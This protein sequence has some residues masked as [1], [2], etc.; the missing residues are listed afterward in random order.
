ME[1][2][3]KKRSKKWKLR[4]KRNFKNLKFEFVI[5]DWNYSFY[6]YKCQCIENAIVPLR[7]LNADDLIKR[8]KE[9]RKK[10][11]EK[12]CK[13]RPN[14]YPNP[15]KIKIF[16]QVFHIHWNTELSW[17]GKLILNGF[18]KKHLYYAID[19]ILYTPNLAL[20]ERDHLLALLYSPAISL[21]N[22]RSIHFFDIWIHELYIKK[23]FKENKF[24]KN[25]CPSS[26]QITIKILYKIRPPRK[27]RET[28]W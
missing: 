13:V 6:K 21:H 25:K 18:Q 8:R 17:V 2:R 3:A 4:K 9:E 1:L 24:L 19:D 26:Y 12:D 5:R 10:K 20:K 11:K 14:L 16:M 15:S 23:I 7:I 27:K 22:T 28:L